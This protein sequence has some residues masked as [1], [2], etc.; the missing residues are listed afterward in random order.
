[1]KQQTVKRSNLI[2]AGVDDWSR[3]VF[4]HVP[5]GGY[6]CEINRLQ[7][8]GDTLKD[9]EELLATGN[10]LYIKTPFK[11]F[12]GEPSHPVNLID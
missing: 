1:M 6:F 3:Y 7:N 12:E 9:V 5:T 8:A 11:D 2:F 4:K 10:A